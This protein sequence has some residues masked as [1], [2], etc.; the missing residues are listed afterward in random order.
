MLAQDNEQFLRF[1]QSAPMGVC[2]LDAS[3]LIAEAVNE[4]YLEIT[5]KT[6]QSVIGQWHWKAFAEARH[7]YE[8]VL[9]KVV[10]TGERY[11]AEDIEISLVRH[12][13]PEQIIVNFVYAPITNEHGQVSKVAV[14]VTEDTKHFEK[15]RSVRESEARLKALVAATSD[16]IYS[17]SPDWEIMHELDGRGFLRDTHQPIIGWRSQNVHPD[18]IDLVNSAITVAIR[19]K[20]T[21][22]LEHRVLR[23]DGSPGWT[24]SRAVPILDPKGDIIEWFGTASDITDMKQSV[25]AL[26]LANERSERQ[27]RV[28]ETITSGTPDLMY[29]WDLDYKFTYANTALLNMWGKSYEDAI[30][31]T[32]LQNGYEPW[33]AA[34]HERELDHIIATKESVRGEVAFPHATLGKRIYDYILIP[35]LNGSGQVEAV[36]GTTRDITELKLSEEKLEKYAEELQA[37]NE[38]MA[39]SNEQLRTTNEE[40]VAVRNRL[41]KTNQEL[42]NSAS[43]LRMAIKTT[44]LG[45]WSYDPLQGSLSWS[46]ECS[47]VYGIRKGEQPTFD[48][49]ADHIYHADRDRV[50]A[51]IQQA[52]DPAGTGEYNLTYRI[53][54]FDNEEVR[55]IKAHGNVF[56]ENGHAVRFIGTVLDV[57]ELKEAEEKNAKLASIVASSDDAIISKTLEGEITSWNAGAENIFG[58]S[59]D[60]MLGQNIYK[61][62]PQDR[63]EEEPRILSQLRKGQRIQ[64]FETK[65]LRKDGHLIDVSL[66][67]SPVRDPQG[68]V[69]GISKIAR[70]IT[71][72][73]QEET[74]KNDFIGM[75]SHELK[76]PL[77]SLGGIV[78]VAN[79]KLKNHEDTFLAAAMGKATSQVRRMTTMINGFLNIARLESGKLS[80][81]K[82]RFDI[83]GLISDTVDELRFINPSHS[84]TF[85]AYRSL[86]VYAD[87]EKIASVLSNYINNAVKYSAK[88]TRVEIVCRKSDSE[89]II[90]V[91]DEGLGIGPDDL[92][93][94]FNRYYRVSSDQTRH[95]SGFGIGLYLSSE[96]IGHHGG[97]V[98]AESEP[99]EGSTFYFSLPV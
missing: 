98:W 25:E 80:I 64:H 81:D 7:Y 75:V 67:I 49:F 78:Q 71:Q 68:N 42:E 54:R 76:T 83:S 91:R 72:K 10:L 14:W 21:F 90:S 13:T 86:E 51:A 8:D 29:V 59:A 32:L 37:I 38:E 87:R 15:R 50:L 6:H 18:D 85:E 93:K 55:W 79:A 23:A 62:I 89:V 73:K 24:Y 31:K 69:I 92:D 45:T 52:M 58:Y 35:V 74:R 26:R 44:N 30:G 63:Q 19:D 40:L 88:D 27:R 3:T 97:R 43:R 11:Q 77:T 47:D 60:E 34:M 28:Y 22:E 2:L 82:Q 9:K 17:V 36:A 99:A 33:H 70:D 57:H 94:I 84:I 48:L 46:E 53:I 41:E 95:I 65:R 4:K 12:E 61:L 39:A 1:I 20:K 5:G 66:T 16:V 96:I 56:F